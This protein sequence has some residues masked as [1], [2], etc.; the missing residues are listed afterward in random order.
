MEF[1]ND[2]QLPN[3]LHQFLTYSDYNLG[4]PKFSISATKLQDS[5]QIAQLWREHG[6]DVVEDS[7][8]RLYSSMGSGIH[9]R[10]EAANAS[11][12]HVMMEKRYLWEFPNPIEGEDPLILSGQ[13][14]A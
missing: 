2:Q 7:S 9:S 6:R 11:N 5:P 12:P 13:I 3:A 10:F 4:G 14:D 8:T 1:S